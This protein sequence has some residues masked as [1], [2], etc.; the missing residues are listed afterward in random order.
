MLVHRTHGDRRLR[1]LASG[2]YRLVVAVGDGMPTPADFTEVKVGR[3]TSLG[4]PYPVEAGATARDVV[5]GFA[6]AIASHGKATA[7]SVGRLL[8]LPIREAQ[9]ARFDLEA[10]DAIED[11]SLR[12]REDGE[13]IAL[14]CPCAYLRSGAPCHAQLL[15]GILLQR[16]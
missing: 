1:E 2:R 7:A 8:Q 5:D 6:C 11:L 16:C 12:L 4:N 13:R 10:A 9:A 3:G 15:V 14:R